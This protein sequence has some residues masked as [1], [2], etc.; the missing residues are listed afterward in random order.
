M[1]R[2]SNRRYCGEGAVR[3]PVSKNWP[4]PLTVLVGRKEALSSASKDAAGALAGDTRDT[5]YP[6]LLPM[7]PSR[8][9]PLPSSTVDR[10]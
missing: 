3:E 9:C 5:H 6:K 10:M 8:F 7:P 4:Q 1:R 2:G